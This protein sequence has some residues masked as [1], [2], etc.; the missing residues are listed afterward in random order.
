VNLIIFLTPHVIRSRGAL[1]NVSAERQKR[2]EGSLETFSEMPADQYRQEVPE[3]A[4]PDAE[5]KSGPRDH[6]PGWPKIE[7][8]E[9]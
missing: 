3:D 5:H 6:F 4:K 9:F 1:A 8:G 7:N 2:F